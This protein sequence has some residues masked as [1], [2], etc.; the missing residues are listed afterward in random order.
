MP[1]PKPSTGESREEFIDRFMSDPTMIADFPSEEQRLAIASSEWDNRNKTIKVGEEVENVKVEKKMSCNIKIHGDED[2]R[3]LRFIVTDESQD[4]DEDILLFEGWNLSRF[5]KNPVGLYMHQYDKPAM[6]KAVNIIKDEIN[7]VVMIDFK[8]PSFDEM[9]SDKNFVSEWAKLTD[10]VFNLYK[11]GYMNAVSVGFDS[12]D[13]IKNPNSQFGRIYKNKS[14]LEVSFV[15][16]PANEN[17]L[18]TAKS[19][20]IIDDEGVKAMKKYEKE[21]KEIDKSEEIITE[22]KKDLFERETDKIIED[23][24]E[25]IEDKTI[26]I[27]NTI[28]VKN[29]ESLMS[30]LHSLIE[31]TSIIETMLQSYQEPREPEEIEPMEVIPVIENFTIDGLTIIQD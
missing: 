8:F 2:D 15:S 14:M 13:F 6:A 16:V 18:L 19:K 12:S 31:A 10:T 26:K 23:I 28:N 29:R 30:V 20:G 21:L 5:V 3:V 22:E 11:N 9:S 4:S 17:A 24:K 25:H 27:G 1:M 7:K